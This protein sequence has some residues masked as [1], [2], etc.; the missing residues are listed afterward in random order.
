MESIVDEGSVSFTRTNP[1]FG[2]SLSTSDLH[3]FQHGGKYRVGPTK[4]LA[5]TLDLSDLKVKNRQQ[6]IKM[7]LYHVCNI[8]H[9]YWLGV[10]YIEWD[11]FPHLLDSDVLIVKA[12]FECFGSPSKLWLIVFSIVLLENPVI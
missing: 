2:M 12:W 1:L 11:D 7:K 10:L 8:V 3:S 4:I 5:Q 6:Y 9:H